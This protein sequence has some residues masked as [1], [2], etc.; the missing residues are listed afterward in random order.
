MDNEIIVYN[1][2]KGNQVSL[3]FDGFD[4]E[5]KLNDEI[6]VTTSDDTEAE[7]IAESLDI[8]LSILYSHDLLKEN[9]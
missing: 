9:S 8:A 3:V 4:Y 7:V 5:I 2:L 6:V 1:E